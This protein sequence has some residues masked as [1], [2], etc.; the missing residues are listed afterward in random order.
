[1][2]DENT[3]LRK[4]PWFSRNWKWVVPVFIVI[5]FCAGVLFALGDI[6]K[7]MGTA[8]SDPELIGKAEQRAQQHPEVQLYFGNELKVG[9]IIE[10]DVLLSEDGKIIRTTVPLKGE[11]GSGMIDIYAHRLDEKWIHDSIHVRLKNPEKRTIKL[12]N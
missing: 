7:G 6:I 4:K 10:G 9:T 2:T 8:M 3:I 11:K 1:M 12:P 5:L